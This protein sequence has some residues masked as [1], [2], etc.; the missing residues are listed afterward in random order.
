MRI[1][2]ICLERFKF[3]CFL[4][5]FLFHFKHANQIIIT[6]IAAVTLAAAFA[7][8]SIDVSA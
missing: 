7:D 3:R 5:Y 2:Y 6:M 1:T 8:V 4:F